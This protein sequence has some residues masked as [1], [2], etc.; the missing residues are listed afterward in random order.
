MTKPPPKLSKKQISEA[1]QHTP[2]DKILGNDI[3]LTSKQRKFTE[4]I[5]LKGMN[6]T[7]AYRNAYDTQGKPNGQSVNANKLSNNTKVSLMIN[8]LQ[9]SET[10]KHLILPTSLRALAIE[11]ITELAIDDD[12]SP[13][14]RLK[15]LELI[16]KFTEVG[17]FEDRDQ[18]ATIVSNSDEVKQQ[19]MDSLR[20]AIG[21]SL[22]V[23]EDKKRSADE[24]LSEIRQGH[25][26][27]A[28][29][30]EDS[31]E[32]SEELHA[33]PHNI[34]DSETPPHPAPL[35]SGIDEGEILHTIPHNQSAISERI[36]PVLDEE[37]E[38]GEGVSEIL[39][40]ELGIDIENTPLDDLDQ[41]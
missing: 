7:E 38:E 13:R 17:L 27:D 2:F 36:T 11:K 15:A 23:S 25:I 18:T 26:Q 4:N 41:N 14:D 40:N 28:E 31:E 5:V 39:R 8:Q 3:K 30:I 21:S 12:I 33:T 16:G 29:L 6:K 9:A 1:I 35:N 37:E 10:I 22:S 32:V 24:L 19:L 20:K 34:A